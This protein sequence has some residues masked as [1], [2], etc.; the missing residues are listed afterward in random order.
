MTDDSVD[1]DAIAEGDTTGDG[2]APDGLGE[3]AP[4]QAESTKAN[5]IGRT[6]VLGERWITVQPPS[7][8]LPTG[9]RRVAR[10]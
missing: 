1:D 2:A 9:L 6:R 5:R 7:V 10:P 4:V 8:R 3:P